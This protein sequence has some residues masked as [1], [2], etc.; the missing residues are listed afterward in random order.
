MGPGPAA[1][2]ASHGTVGHAAAAAPDGKLDEFKRKCGE[3]TAFD[4]VDSAVDALHTFKDGRGRTA[5]H[6]AALAHQREVCEH[7]HLLDSTFVARIPALLQVGA[8]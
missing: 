5:M 1:P 3:C 7:I 4:G 2:A 6:F 8:L